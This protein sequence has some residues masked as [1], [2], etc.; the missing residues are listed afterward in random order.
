[1]LIK[2]STYYFK[3]ATKKLW[4]VH[5]RIMRVATMRLRTQFILLYY[6]ILLHCSANANE[7]LELWIILN[8][9]TCF[10][11]W[12]WAAWAIPHPHNKPM[13]AIT[14]GAWKEARSGQDQGPVL[15]TSLITSEIKWHIQD[16]IILLIMI[17]LIRFFEHTCCLWLV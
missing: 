16:D 7:H 14:E 4:K 12:R 11:Q 13:E 1:M 17:W 10:V 6:Y 2:P 5:R 9:L 15:R 8:L 3:W